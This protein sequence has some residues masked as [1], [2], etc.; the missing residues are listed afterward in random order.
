[1]DYDLTKEK[2]FGNG[3]MF[4]IHNKTVDYVD[5]H[6]VKELLEKNKK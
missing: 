3:W 5:Y 1:M 4:D 2:A 6:I